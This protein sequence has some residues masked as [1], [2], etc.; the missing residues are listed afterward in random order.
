MSQINIA[1]INV[2]VKK[3]NMLML[4]S[5]VMNIRQYHE[6]T[7]IEGLIYR[8][9]FP[10]VIVV[11]PNIPGSMSSGLE[12]CSPHGLS[13]LSAIF[14]YMDNKFALSGMIYE[15]FNSNFF[16]DLPR[17][18]QRNIEE[19]EVDVIR[20]LSL[21]PPTIEHLEQFYS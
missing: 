21:Y 8:L 12:V 1:D 13:K 20:I 14:S 15:E 3:M 16:A 4:K 2:D 11:K 7:I 18:A 6:S 10:K 17:Q 19:Y 5:L 9:P